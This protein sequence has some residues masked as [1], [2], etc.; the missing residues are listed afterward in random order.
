MPTGSGLKEHHTG[1]GWQRAVRKFGQYFEEQ[2]LGPKDIPVA[3]VVHELLGLL[4][5]AGAWTVGV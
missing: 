3:I 2:G 1:S 5:A 4:I